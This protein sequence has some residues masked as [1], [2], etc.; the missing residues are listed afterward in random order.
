M[1]FEMTFQLCAMIV[2]FARY[3][4]RTCQRVALWYGGDMIQFGI[5]HGRM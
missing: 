4:P 5:P 1:P 3:P 2:D